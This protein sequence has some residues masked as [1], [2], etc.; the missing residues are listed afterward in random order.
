MK[1]T[2][3]RS[4]TGAAMLLVAAV[5]LLASCEGN[6]QPAA[7]SDP[8]DLDVIIAEGTMEKSI[9]GYEG[10][11]VGSGTTEI[12]Q[13]SLTVYRKGDTAPYIAETF[14]DK[15]DT[16]YVTGQSYHEQKYT[17]KNIVA[18]SYDFLVRGF[19]NDHLVAEDRYNYNITKDTDTVGPL[20]LDT[21]VDDAVG[22]ITI[23]FNMPTDLNDGAAWNVDL[24]LAIYE[25]TGISGDAV[26][27]ITTTLSGDAGDYAAQYVLEDAK[28]TFRAL[29]GGLYT[30]VATVEDQADSEQYT[31]IELMRLFPGLP[32]EGSISFA[33]SN[34]VTSNVNFSIHDST[35]AEIKIG[36]GGMFPVTES[37]F[38]IHMGFVVPSDVT[39]AFYMDGKEVATSDAGDVYYTTSEEA[40]EADDYG[41]RPGN[42][43]VYTFS[44]VDSTKAHNFTA[45][46]RK[47]GTTIGAGSFSF[48]TAPDSLEPP[49]IVPQV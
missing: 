44:N 25:G 46:L 48:T 1:K 11:D 30:I 47:T 23:N 20:V 31:S 6:P 45:V 18:G 42:E 41:V 22:D 4:V 12:T 19:I 43:T 28:D 38:A 5:M 34:P 37:G 39:V 16:G 17:V 26:Q 7:T 32:A 10:D 3:F 29:Q 40:I 24:T 14:F 15:D 21:L 27:T 36:I 9:T 33:A 2:I 49:V 8:F 35:G 13:Y